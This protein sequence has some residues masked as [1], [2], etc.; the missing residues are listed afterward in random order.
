[1]HHDEIPGLVTISYDI[2]LKPWQNDPDEYS[3]RVMASI[4]AYVNGRNDPDETVAAGHIELTVIKLAEVTNDK[5]MLSDVFDACGLPV[6]FSS[7][8]DDTGLRTDLE[9]DFIPGDVV[10]IRSVKLAPKYLR[11][12][13]FFQAV[14]T[15]LAAIA[16]I[17][18]VAA[19]KDTLDLGK[20]EWTQLGFELIPG[21]DFIYRDNYSVHPDR[22]AY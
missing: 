15:T 16:T 9:I 19:I 4:M 11:T 14:E 10:F 7:L 20:R 13:L 2:A 3:V 22:K 18:L 8:F 12:R 5:M 6:L 17:G 21:T 1:M